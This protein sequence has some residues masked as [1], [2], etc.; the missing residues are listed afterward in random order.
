M[1]NLGKGISDYEDIEKLQSLWEEPDKYR[2]IFQED[3]FIISGRKGSGKSTIVDYRAL[4]SSA[5]ERILAIRPREDAELY[6]KVREITDQSTMKYGDLRNSI[7]KL[8]ELLAYVFS[9]RDLVEGKEEHLL[10]GELGII[11]S[12]LVKNKLNKGS[13]IKRTLDRMA[14]L[15]KNFTKLNTLFTLLD[16]I[17][18]PTFHDAKKA[19]IAHLNSNKISY[20]VFIDDID[21]YGFEY[22]EE[23]KAFLDALV[24]TSMR[25][26]TY[27]ARNG[28][29]FRLVVTPPTELFDNAKFWNRDKILTKTV[30]L[31]WSNTQKL[32]NLINKRIGA[33][34]KIHKRKKRY[35]NDIWSISTVKTWDQLFP[36]RIYN[37]IGASEPTLQYI[38]RHTFYTPRTVLRICQLTLEY[39]QEEGYALNTLHKATETEWNFAIQNACEEQ[40]IVISKNIFDIY[41]TMY[42]NL[43]DLLNQFE[44]RP[45]LWTAQNFRYFI[46]DRCKN[47]ITSIGSEKYINGNE[48]IRLLYLMGLVGFA[49]RDQSGAPHGRVHFKCYFSFLKWTERKQWEFIVLSPVFYDFLNI[50]P[51]NAIVVVPHLPL[52]LKKTQPSFISNYNYQTNSF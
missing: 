40:S 2:D 36:G 23:N 48:L 27:C 12:F 5:S 29:N 16:N 44:G 3:Y 26:N 19:F 31:R 47:I 46:S 10:T 42:K 39:L 18:A 1:L 11:Y 32:Q 35:E 24:I 13:V 37:R 33:E 9:M 20:K 4:T 8:F 45:N 15:T 17:E 30:F 14:E 25:L 49:F 22:N 21:G 50:Q 34:L 38:I 43:Q 52:K 51:M 41:D 7:A 6:D 28:I